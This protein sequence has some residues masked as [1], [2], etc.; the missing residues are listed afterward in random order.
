MISRALEGL[1]QPPRRR[2]R[3]RNSRWD[4]IP[5]SVCS[6]TRLR[7]SRNTRGREP[8]A[9]KR[10]ARNS[11][12]GFERRVGDRGTA[13]DRAHFQPQTH[14]DC[15]PGF[16]YSLRTSRAAKRPDFQ[17]LFPVDAAR[18]RAAKSEVTAVHRRALDMSPRTTN[19]VPIFDVDSLPKDPGE[20]VVS[21]WMNPTLSTPPRASARELWSG[22]HNGDAADEFSTRASSSSTP[23]AVRASRAV[24]RACDRCAVRRPQTVTVLKKMMKLTLSRGRPRSTPSRTR[25]ELTR[26]LCE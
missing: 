19:S 14:L 23:V 5:A 24:A 25:E 6:A 17:A 1:R 20:P 9:S 22:V 16:A 18:I 21:L 10:N 8:C 11:T 13:L 26:S 3:R 15:A 7:S 4:Q 2:R 12:W